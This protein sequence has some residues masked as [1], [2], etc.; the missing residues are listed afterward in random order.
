VL[1]QQNRIV[2]LN[3]AA[4]RIVGYPSSKVVGKPADQVLA[5]WP[6]L[7]KGYRDMAEVR[8]EIIRGAGAGQ[9]SFDLRLSPLYDRHG[10]LT[11]R[12]FVLNDI[13]ERRQAEEALGESEERFRTIFEEAPIGM[14]VVS[15]DDRLLKVNKAFSEMLGYTE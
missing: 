5:D 9:R 6:D 1:D 15:L 10:R 11:G 2:D 4:Q 12:L 8:A 7:V 3:P 13:T 14:G